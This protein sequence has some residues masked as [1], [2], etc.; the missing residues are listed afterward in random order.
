MLPPSNFSIL[1]NMSSSLLVV[2]FPEED[3][4]AAGATTGGDDDNAEDDNGNGVC[5]DVGEDEGGLGM[6][7]KF[8][9]ASCFSTNVCTMEKVLLVVQYTNTACGMV[10]VNGI[11]AKA[12]PR[13]THLKVSCWAVCIPSAPIST[14]KRNDNPLAT[15]KIM[16]GSAADKSTNQYAPPVVIAGKYRC[17]SFSAKKKDKKMGI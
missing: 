16:Y 9:T 6:S 7:N 8:R 13:M 15:G 5:G 14:I 2:D 4:T 11:M 17:I 10:I 12:N 3:V 1:A